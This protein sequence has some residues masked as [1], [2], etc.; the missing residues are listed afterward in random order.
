[1]EA[2][3]RSK[4]NAERASRWPEAGA[5]NGKGLAD[6]SS[7]PLPPTSALPGKRGW[8]ERDTS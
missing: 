1:L 6:E 3:R 7:T 8:V 4:F 5:P 2:E